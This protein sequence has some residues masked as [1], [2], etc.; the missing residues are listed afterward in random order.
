MQVGAKRL[1]EAGKQGSRQLSGSLQSL[2]LR[3]SGTGAQNRANWQSD[4][5]KFNGDPSLLLAKLG[6]PRP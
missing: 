3:P 2:R 1:A 6:E 5:T 4:S